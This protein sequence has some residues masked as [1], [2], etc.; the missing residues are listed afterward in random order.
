MEDQIQTE[1]NLEMMEAVGAVIENVTSEIEGN[2]MCSSFVNLGSKFISQVQE[3][4]KDARYKYDAAQ[5]VKV[6][7]AMISVF[8]K[9]VVGEEPEGEPEGEPAEETQE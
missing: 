2:V 1:E 5:H 7:N 4:G 9:A 6:F 3:T 8:N